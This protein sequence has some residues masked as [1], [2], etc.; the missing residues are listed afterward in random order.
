MWLANR[1]FP[2]VRRLQGRLAEAERNTYRRVMS[3]E[4][5]GAEFERLGP[6]VTQF[7]INGT[8]FGGNR[9][10][11]N[12]A[13]NGLFDHVPNHDRIL[14]LGTLDGGHTL[15]LAQAP[16]VREVV[17]IDAREDS[18]R[19]ANFVLDL[20]GVKNASI[21]IRDLRTFDVS[22]LG[23]F[24][25]VF[26]SGVL[27]H[28]T[29]PWKLIEQCAKITPALHIGTLYAPEGR[30]TSTI[31]GYNLCGYTEGELD[32]PLSG[33]Q[34]ESL[35]FTLPSLFRILNDV[36]YRKIIATGHTQEYP[37][38]PGISLLALKG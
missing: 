19:R 13:K 7:R 30:P 10:D 3:N 35:W 31:N 33:L 5:I 24:D 9:I 16:G 36:G 32:N 21:I 12:L 14:E 22:T 20:H 34:S 18:V 6:W 4:Q 8:V 28:L 1:L 25:F 26:C 38:G 27:Y 2:S 29:E 11:C 15:A 23:P 17:G 37:Q